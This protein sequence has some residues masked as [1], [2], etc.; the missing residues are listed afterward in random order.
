MGSEDATRLT[1]SAGES[2]V[3]LPITV[4]TTV[5]VNDHYALGVHLAHLN[6]DQ[7]ALVL[8]GLA[9]GIRSLGDLSSSM[10]TLAIVDSMV[11]L[12]MAE[13]RIAAVVDWCSS[14]VGFIADRHAE[15]RCRGCGKAATTSSGMCPSCAAD[16]M[17]AAL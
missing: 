13:S 4:T 6:S 9:E 8:A 14:L 2:V 16:E 3:D 5:Q 12:G 11:D 10:Q 15:G 7:Q 17:A 1:V